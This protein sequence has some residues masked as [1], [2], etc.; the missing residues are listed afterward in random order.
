MNVH[1]GN[2]WFEVTYNTE[3]IVKI[4]IFYD[5]GNPEPKSITITSADDSLWTYDRDGNETG[6][7]PVGVYKTL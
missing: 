1:I 5:P 3:N 2:S 4:E 7:M 6:A